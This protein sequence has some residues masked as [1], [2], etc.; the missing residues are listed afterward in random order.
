VLERQFGFTKARYPGLA[1]NTA[2]V[3]T[4]FALGN[5][6]MARRQLLQGRG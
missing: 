5:L 3:V 4:M 6:W 1:K 2:Q